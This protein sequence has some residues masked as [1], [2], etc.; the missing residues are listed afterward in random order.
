MP[1]TSG[2]EARTAAGYRSVC[3]VVNLPEPVPSHSC[4]SPHRPSLPHPPLPVA[5]SI[6]SPSS[7]LLVSHPPS[8]CLPGQTPLHRGC[9]GW[10]SPVEVVV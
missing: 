9:S 10:A 2:Q 4:P 8:V 5:L 3:R 7:S 6:P 1:A